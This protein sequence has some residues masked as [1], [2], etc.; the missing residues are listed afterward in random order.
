[1]IL[2][3]GAGTGPAL[4]RALVLVARQRVVRDRRDDQLVRRLDRRCSCSKTQGVVFSTHVAL[5]TTVAITTVC[6]VATAY[7]GPETDRERA[8]QVLA[9]GAAGRSGLGAHP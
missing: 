4:S 7:L 9:Q 1:M 3:V 5:L 2:Q 8:H 6:W